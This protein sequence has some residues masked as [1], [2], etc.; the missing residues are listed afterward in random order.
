MP[1]LRLY[2]PFLNP[3]HFTKMTPDQ[4]P[5][6][7]SKHM[8]DWQF[9]DTILPWEQRVCFHQCWQTSDSI[10]LQFMSNYSPLNLKLIRYADDVVVYD[11]N[12][13]QVLQNMDDPTYYIYQADV[14]LNPFPAGYY[15]LK[16]TVGSGGVLILVSGIMEISEIIE[17]TLLLGYQHRR[18]R[19]DTFFETGF[20]PT[21]RIH[22]TLKMKEPRS[23][24]TVY[25]DQEANLEMIKSVPYQVMN[26]SIGGSEGIPSWVIKRINFM[27]GCSSFRV[28]GRY[29]TKNESAKLEESTEEFYPMSGWSIEM[30]E[31]L[32]RSSIIYENELVVDGSI[33]VVANVDSKG[34]APN[35]SGG[36]VYQ[37]EDIQ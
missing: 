30:R 13:A 16:L 8:D 2:Q 33:V 21:F 7:L 10:R 18:Y 6:Y 22:G 26:L 1:T 14:A 24:D 34:F 29:Y 17:N 23:I 3:V 9:P 20:A 36:S 12:L 15:Y 27:L 19:A 32:N 25:E 4:V 37:V 35:D 28:D 5:Q 11:V 31:K